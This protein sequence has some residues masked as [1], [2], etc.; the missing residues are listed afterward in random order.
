MRRECVVGFVDISTIIQMQT[1]L[2][3]F[4]VRLHLAADGAASTEITYS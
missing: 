2:L 3:F 4:A 1:V